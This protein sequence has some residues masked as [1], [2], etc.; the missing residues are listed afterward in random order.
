[1]HHIYH[2]GNDAREKTQLENVCGRTKLEVD[3]QIYVTTR[4]ECTTM[5][6]ARTEQHYNA[7]EVSECPLEH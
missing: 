7:R 2:A 6:F 3:H 4:D 5:T 1:M